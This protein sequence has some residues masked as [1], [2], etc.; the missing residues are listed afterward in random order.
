MEQGIEIS[1]PSKKP[2]KRRSDVWTNYEAT[3]EG[4]KC[5]FCSRSFQTS[6][7]TSSLRY[8]L[9]TA[10]K[11]TSTTISNSSNKLSDPNRE[12]FHSER[13]EQLMLKF[14]SKNYLSYRLL[15][16]AEFREFI[17]YLQP[18]FQL[19]G[20]AQVSQEILPAIRSRIEEVITQI[21][22]TVCFYSLSLDSCTSVTD[23]TYLIVSFHGVTKQWTLESFVLGVLSVKRS[24]N[25]ESI[26][27]LI[28]E[29][30]QQWGISLENLIS[31]TTDIIPTMKSAVE[32]RLGLPWVY[33]VV[34][35]INHSI[36]VGLS[37]DIISA[38]VKKAS[39]ICKFFR[40]STEASNV[41]RQQQE[42]IGIPFKKIALNSKA[43]W[44]STFRMLKRMIANRPAISSSLSILDVSRHLS[45]D[46]LRP[47]EWN[48]LIEIAS[49]LQSMI[50]AI[51]F[52]SREKVPT[53]GFTMPIISQILHYHLAEK[54]EDDEIVRNFKAA[55]QEDLHSRWSSITLASPDII[56]LSVY[57]DPRFKS[58]SFLVD[59]TLQTQLLTRSFSLVDH[60]INNLDGILIKP[61]ENHNLS[62]VGEK[63]NPSETISSSQAAVAELNV[64]H[65]SPVCKFFENEG[66]SSKITDALVWWKEN[67]SRFPC[68]A[69]LARRFF[70]ITATSF[71]RD[72]PFSKH[73]WALTKRR[74]S[75][76]DS[77]ASTLTFLSCNYHLL[78]EHAI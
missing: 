71:P 24:E 3:D 70:C 8:H 67:E 14:L 29:L 58:F 2:F 10:H 60:L 38:I 36:Q 78:K 53:I 16:N 26:A 11:W 23:Q 22:S 55:M 77:N 5:K 13:A 19:P 69:K 27:T 37:L 42:Q 65:Q 35:A 15:E 32:D 31:V 28:R 45:P 33:C 76:S 41:L 7:S 56:L 72:N 74:A 51:K 50:Q 21:L 43:R 68:L 47:N 30:L 12:S 34:H 73:G 61:E 44:N 49:V 54:Q 17:E 9:Q 64:Y 20:R 1:T 40:R 62:G 46:D 4:K 75:L 57:F 18:L 25:A 59:E 52:I 63:L 6:T 48:L 66:V 39:K